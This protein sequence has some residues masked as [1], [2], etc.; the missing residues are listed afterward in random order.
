MNQAKQQ[1]LNA[2]KKWVRS[3]REPVEGVDYDLIPVSYET[4]SKIWL[5]KF[6]TWDE[7]HESYDENRVYILYREQLDKI[8][9]VNIYIVETFFIE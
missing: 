3:N 2:V 5:G 9:D 7:V 6:K 4:A 1:G 8:R